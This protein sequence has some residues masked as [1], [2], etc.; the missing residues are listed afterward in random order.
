M[1]VKKNITAIIIPGNHDD[2]P[3]DKWF[4]YLERELPKI[5]IAV[6]NKKFPD[7]V[8]ARKRYWLPFIEKLGADENTILIGHS[9]GAIAA[10]CFA[11]THAILGSVLV[12]A[13][14]SHLN[15]PDE[16]A[17][18]YFDV[19]WDFARIKKNQKWLVQ[20]A[21][22]DDPFIPIAEAR[23]GHRGLNTEYHEYTDEGH[24]G[25][26]DNKTEFPEIVEAIQR[27]L[28]SKRPRLCHSRAPTTPPRGFGTP[29]RA[30]GEGNPDSA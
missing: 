11:E 22:T 6:V 8:L 15:E 26:R 7:A 28:K 21:S 25:S 1:K 29:P 13:Y 17:S 27:N 18:G 16:I 5:G 10:L 19:P 23:E 30:G 20:F 3:G 2:N 24:F 12:G 4:P 9:S 14:I